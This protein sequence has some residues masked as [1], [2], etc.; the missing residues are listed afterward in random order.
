MMSLVIYKYILNRDENGYCS[1]TLPLNAETLDVQFQRG[2]CCL[3]ALVNPDEKSR[4]DIFFRVLL[5]G[6]PLKVPIDKTAGRRA[7][8]LRGKYLKTLQLD[9]LVYHVFQVQ[10]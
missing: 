6:E 9:S 7:F 4:E 10:K 1:V 8:G 3:W 5:T 2:V